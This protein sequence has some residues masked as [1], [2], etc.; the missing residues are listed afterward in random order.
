MRSP[1]G[2]SVSA[3]N[4]FGDDISLDSYQFDGFSAKWDCDEPVIVVSGFQVSNDDGR[5]VSSSSGLQKMVIRQ[6]CLILGL[7]AKRM[8]GPHYNGNT[9]KSRCAGVRLWRSIAIA[10]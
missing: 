7:S 10:G 3:M 9:V 6:T 2:I 5:M 1:F 4:P 8:L